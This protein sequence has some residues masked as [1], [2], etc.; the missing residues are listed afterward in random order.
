[1]NIL[2][3]RMNLQNS[4][5]ATNFKT[6]GSGE[7]K[8]RY[9][10]GLRRIEYIILVDKIN[11]LNSFSRT[12]MGKER[13]KRNWESLKIRL[14]VGQIVEGIIT[15]VETYGVYIDIGEIFEGIVLIPQLSLIPLQKLE[16]YPKRGDSI[17]GIIVDFSDGKNLDY[18]FANISISVKQYLGRN[19]TL[20]SSGKKE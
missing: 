20:D 14:H 1:M 2:F 8:D 15:R 4:Y 12:K 3:F 6:N 19:I 9:L 11:E 5:V 18:E 16:D 13:N 10:D 7:F 17:K